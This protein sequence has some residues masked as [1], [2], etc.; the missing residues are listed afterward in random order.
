M[1]S[2]LW[3][4]PVF[5]KHSKTRH[6]ACPGVYNLWYFGWDVLGVVLTCHWFVRIHD[7]L[8]VACIHSVSS[9]HQKHNKSHSYTH[10]KIHEEKERIGDGRIINI[11]LQTS[12]WKER[13]HHNTGWVC[14]ATGSF[15]HPRQDFTKSRSHPLFWV[16]R[17]TCT[18]TVLQF[19]CCLLMR[20]FTNT[21]SARL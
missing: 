19:F 11:H 10:S 6:W 14:R 13:C 3:S 12:V 18:Y 17:Y 21:N 9:V 5:H 20:S 15:V 16:L 8:L 7:H 4:F 2:V 1:R